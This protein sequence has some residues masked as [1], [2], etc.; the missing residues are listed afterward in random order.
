MCCV[1]RLRSQPLAV[2]PCWLRVTR[3]SGFGVVY[4]REYSV[5]PFVI[6]RRGDDL[7]KIAIRGENSNVF[8]LTPSQRQEYPDQR[9]TLEVNGLWIVNPLP[10][11]LPRLDSSPSLE[12]IDHGPTC[13]EPI[14]VDSVQNSM[15]QR[16]AAMGCVD[17]LR[18][19]F[20]HYAHMRNARQIHEMSDSL[21][22]NP[23]VRNAY[24]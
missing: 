10:Q 16:A 22:P 14:S 20:P 17:R 23:A 6:P 5:A 12:E 8:A 21:W 13:D 19:Q 15:S 1:D 3:R 24:V 2:V 4:R 7:F 11:P 9:L 18:S